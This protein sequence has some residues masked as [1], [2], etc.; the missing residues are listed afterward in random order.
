MKGKRVLKL[1]LI[2]ILGLVAF[3]AFGCGVGGGGGGGGGGQTFTLAVTM[4]GTGSGRV[5]SSPDGIFCE[6]DCSEVYDSDTQV[7]LTAAPYSGSMFAGWSG[8]GCS[9]TGTCIL[10]MNN[11]TTVTA[12]FNLIG[13]DMADMITPY[14]NESDMTEIRDSFSSDKTSS[15]QNRVHDGF[16]I[17]PNGDLKPFQAVCSGRVHW[18]Y[19]GDEQVIVML[20]CNST[21]IAEY[22]FEPQAA[23][24]GQTQLAN[25]PVIVGQTVSQGDIIGYLYAANLAA[26]HVHFTFNK[27]WVPS[28]PEPYFSSEAGNSMLNLIRVVFPTADMCY[29]GDVTPPPLVTPYM[30]ESDMTEINAGFSSENSFS[31]WGFVHD[32]MDIYP[33]GD[34][35]PFQASCSGTVDSVELRQANPG[36]NWQVDVLIACN[37]YV[38]DPDLGGYFTPFSVDYVF[39]P[40]SNIQTDGQTQLANIPV[41]EGQ[42]V[43]QGDIIGYLYVAG[44]GAH[45]HFGLVQFGG[46][47]F[48]ALGVPSIPIC[49]EPHFSTEGKDSILNLLYVVWPSANMCYQN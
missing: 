14:V 10:T 38:P 23:N 2:I 5:S 44:E 25:I 40:M 9:G 4:N 32:G 33:Q 45:V 26:A 16:D 39:E 24:T 22:N 37:D 20:A 21:Y 42:T 6:T 29:G 49:P 41:S 34:L 48:S 1:A 19:T 11:D 30:N 27:N 43:S 8:A 31:P 12:I 17:S 46:S 36:S 13:S 3:F 35:K 7:T 47:L 18:I 15:P 28:C